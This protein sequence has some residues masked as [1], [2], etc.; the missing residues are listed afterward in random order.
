MPESEIEV[1]DDVDEVMEEIV[2][3]GEVKEEESRG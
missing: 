1:L 2:E 3:E